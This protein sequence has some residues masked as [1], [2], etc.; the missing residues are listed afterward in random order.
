MVER[1]D[2]RSYA[3]ELARIFSGRRCS[4]LI[5]NL[6][7][8]V[9]TLPAG[10][11]TLSA[12]INAAGAP[13]CYLVCPSAAYVDYAREELR[14][15]GGSPLVQAAMR[16]VLAGA[17]PLM[18]ATG[19]DR[20]IQPNNFLLATNI[21]CRL[22]RDEI[23]ALTVE[24]IRERPGLAIVWR[25]LNALTD[26]QALADFRAAGYGLY[27][28]RQIY[29]FDCRTGEPPVRRDE[30]RD[31]ALLARDDF[32]QVGPEDLRPDDFARIEA[33][34]AMLYLDKYTPLNPRYTS[35]FMQAAHEAGLIRFLGLRSPGG[36]LDGIIGLFEK[37][38]VMTAPI[39]GYDTHVD[40]SAGLYRRLMA[41]GQQRARRARLLYHMSAGAAGFKRNRGA[42]PAIEYTA[43]YNRHLPL[44]K[45]VAGAVVRALLTGVGVPLMRRF[46]L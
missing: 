29:L 26:A 20:Q 40:Q 45:R 23:E 25:S 39:V 32:R 35:P 30:R 3:A 28:A 14:N 6:E 21:W 22:S 18:R 34:Y 10:G 44:G 2:A 19:F 17:G 5:A 31:L 7:T 13:T 41:M 27:P 33:L 8:E 37:D 36:Q 43:I 24:L 4:A 12:T 46:E 15:L 1:D 9:L 38:G 42:V 11:Q 16:G